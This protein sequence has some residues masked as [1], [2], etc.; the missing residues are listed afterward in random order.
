MKYFFANMYKLTKKSILRWIDD[1]CPRMGATVSYY[2]VFSIAPLI[3]LSISIGGLV[4]EK[5]AV[6][7]EIIGQLKGL[8]G[9]HSI[10]AIEMLLEASYKPA[11]GIISTCLGVLALLIGASGVVIELQS[12]INKI[13]RIEEKA[14]G[15]WVVVKKRLLSMGMVLG[16]GFLL[17]VSLI[18]SAALA[19]MGKF[20]NGLLPLPESAMHIMSMFFSFKDYG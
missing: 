5:S 12:A 7:A 6:Q 1:D 3:L 19:A 16:T 17:L 2:V 14:Q 10:G 18:V 13:W 15:W 4:F 9:E 8:F 20:M 11:A